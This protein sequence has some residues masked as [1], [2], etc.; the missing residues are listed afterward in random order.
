MAGPSS[1]SDNFH[2]WTETLTA[3]SVPAAP[4]CVRVGSRT[5]GEVTFVWK[6]ARPHGSP[7]IEQEIRYQRAD[8]PEQNTLF[9]AEAAEFTIESMA[10][11][12]DVIGVQVRWLS[13]SLQPRACLGSFN[14]CRV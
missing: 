11:G 4:R 13:S 2:E 5:T 10:P 6:P 12:S 14:F 3:A 1:V 8:E 9:R 7:L